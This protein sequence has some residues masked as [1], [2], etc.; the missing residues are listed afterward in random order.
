[1]P[2]LA[3]L[4]QSTEK[5]AFEVR[6]QSIIMHND[7]T[8]LLFTLRD[9]KEETCEVVQRRQSSLAD[10]NSA[11]RGALPSSAIAFLN[12]CLHH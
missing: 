10:A 9:D 8:Y 2:G 5:E 3:S 11:A 1:M 4:F 12:C 7:S 6:Q